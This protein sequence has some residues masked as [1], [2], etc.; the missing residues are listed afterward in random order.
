MK[1]AI[2]F[3][4]CVRTLKYTIENTIKTIRKNIGDC[5]IY[6]FYSFW[7]LTDKPI[8]VPDIFCTSVPENGID[9]HEFGGKSEY[10]S[11]NLFVPIISEN[12]IKKC[13]LNSGSDFVDGEIQSMDISKKIIEESNFTNIP[14]LSSQYYKIHRV[15]E[16]FPPKKYDLCLRIRAD[17]TINNFPKLEQLINLNNFLFINRWLWPG[18]HSD[19]IACNEMVW[20]STPD[21][22]LDTCSVYNN[23][24]SNFYDVYSGEPVTANHFSNLINSGVVKK[25]DFF[26]FQ[27]IAMRFSPN[28]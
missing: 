25:Y 22:F 1:I 10:R 7:D 11:E 23:K 17:T 28:G 18:A 24:N 12:D 2:Y 20:C 4:G 3:S 26:D 8:D 9:R 16:K 21:I 6:T 15:V 19:L 14:K 5:E 27:H 13:I